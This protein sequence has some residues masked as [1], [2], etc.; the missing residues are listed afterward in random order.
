MM[1]NADI[2][3]N[4]D[5]YK[6]LEINRQATQKQVKEAYLRLCKIHH[7]DKTGTQDSSNFQDVSKA[8][9]ILSEPHRRRQY[10]VMMF[11]KRFK[12]PVKSMYTGSYTT[13]KPIHSVRVPFTKILK[14]L[15]L[16]QTYLR[17]DIPISFERITECEACH[18]FGSTCFKTCETCKGEKWVCQAPSSSSSSSFFSGEL[19]VNC[20]TCGGKGMV[21]STSSSSLPPTLKRRKTS[22]NQSPAEDFKCISCLGQGSTTQTVSIP[23]PFPKDFFNGCCE[24]FK[25]QG[26]R[27]IDATTHGDVVVRFMVELDHGN[28]H[29]EGHGDTRLRYFQYLSLSEA[30]A[31]TAGQ[32]TTIDGRII[33]INRE[34]TRGPISHSEEFWIR[35]EGLW[36]RSGSWLRVVFQIKPPSFS[37]TQIQTIQTWEKSIEN[38]W[39]A[40]CGR[41]G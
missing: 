16:Q 32:L 20:L 36:A 11:K 41:S 17:Q 26:D 6:I 12:V 39:S 28:F 21:F 37:T 7:P 4:N 1:N 33:A 13:T 34:K 5:Y 14:L 15:S 40:F 18:G 29:F 19:F 24:V 8:Y 35:N 2:S 9:V 22:E 25:G 38:S 27:R 23:C 10:D 31:G 3:T 30:L